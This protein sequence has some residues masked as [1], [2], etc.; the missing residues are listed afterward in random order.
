MKKLLWLAAAVVSFA[1]FGSAGAYASYVHLPSS[2]YA[3]ISHTS[4]WRQWGQPRM[5]SG[6]IA[7][8]RKWRNAH[9]GKHLDYGDISKRGGGYFPPHVS[10]RLGV[11]VD[12]RPITT[13]GS[14]GYTSVGWRNYSTYYN[15]Q[16]ARMQRTCWRVRLMLHNNRRIPGCTYWRNHANH[17]HTRIW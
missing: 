1:G 7:L 9:P 17:F 5:V 16:Y 15:I 6:L 12:T 13:S 10:H 11:D 3:Y 2:G 14:A 4:S 8:G